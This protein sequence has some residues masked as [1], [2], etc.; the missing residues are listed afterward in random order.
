M[1]YISE[2]FVKESLGMEDL[3]IEN[4]F[5]KRG[6]VLYFTSEYL[7]EAENL[8]IKLSNKFSEDRFEIEVVKVFTDGNNS[9]LE[10]IV[11]EEEVI[12]E[13]VKENTLLD[14]FSYIEYEE[15]PQN[16]MMFEGI[17][18]LIRGYISEGHFYA[19]DNGSS[20][21]KNALYGDFM[22]IFTIKGEV[23]EGY[24]EGNLMLTNIELINNSTKEVIK[25]FDKVN[26]T[27]NFYVEEDDD[28]DYLIEAYLESMSE[29]DIE[30][31]FMKCINS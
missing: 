17:F 19:D 27:S 31:V 30:E 2:R 21:F 13:Q 16:I 28:I 4:S 24:Y 7:N 3:F 20:S 18:E 11:K 23:A 14:F 22:N 29:S 8:C 15:N 1:I 9:A 5:T 12:D 26:I 25:D 10:S 6:D